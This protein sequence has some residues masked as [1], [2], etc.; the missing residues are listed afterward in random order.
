MRPFTEILTPQMHTHTHTHIQRPA[1]TMTVYCMNAKSPQLVH[2]L[3]IRSFHS[4]YKIE[5]EP[6]LVSIK[7]VIVCSFVLIFKWAQGLERQE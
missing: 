3:L 2:H 1:S 6:F 7:N 4:L 5:I